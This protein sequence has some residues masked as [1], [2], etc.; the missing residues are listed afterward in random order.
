MS[1]RKFKLINANGA[2][3]DLMRKDGF[4]HE[5]D[6]LGISQQNEYM[7]IGNTYEMIQ[8]LSA[9]KSISFNM[10]FKDY[11]IYRQFAD[12]IIYQPLKL[13]Y[14]PMSEWVYCDGEITDM[15]KGEIDYQTNRLI[16]NTTFT[17]T[18]LWYIPRQARRTADDVENP[19]KY[20]YQYDYQ[21]ADAINGYI[22]VVNNSNEDAQGTITIFGEITNPSWYVSVNNNVIESG[23]VTATIPKGNK[24]VINSKDGQLEVAEY[25]GN[26]DEYVR[27]LYQA[28]DFSKETFVHFP[29]GNSVLFVSGSADEP[30]DA[31]VQIDEVHD[32]V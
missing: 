31:W 32:T 12:F 5:P 18:S 3:W 24:L 23:S 7:R 10:V 6:G 29:P 22:N 26:T 20:T 2:E 13:A 14:M 4:L 19:K 27:N 28:T 30:I 11:A 9:Q 15:S 21:Y 25:V 8:R 17:A 16:C 1:V